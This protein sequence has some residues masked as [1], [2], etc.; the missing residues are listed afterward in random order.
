MIDE[1]QLTDEQQAI[2]NQLL[3]TCK[4]V[5]EHLTSEQ[6]L[7]ERTISNE[8]NQFIPTSQNYLRYFNLEV[9]PIPGEP[10]GF[11]TIIKRNDHQSS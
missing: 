8:Q 1:R 4:E 11:S 7:N 2:L 5:W 9:E 6:D 10:Y 3:T